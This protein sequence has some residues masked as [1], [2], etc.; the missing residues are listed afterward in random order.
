[1]LFTPKMYA[2]SA[3]LALCLVGCA[4]APA[5]PSVAVFPG[6]GKNFDDF[7][8]DDIVCRQFAQE[9]IGGVNATRDAN[10]NAVKNGVVGTM[11]GAVIGAAIGGRDGAA[12]GA[13]S[14][15]LVGSANGDASAQSSSHGM[16]RRYDI[17]YQQ[18]MYAKGNQ[19]PAIGQRRGTYRE[20]EPANFPPPN[21]PPPPP[22]AAP[23]R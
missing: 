7:R 16:Q 2:V 13:G 9:Q 3:T 8:T 1:M 21:T 14:G 15:L 11:V 12:V 10:D 20:A 5:G 17:A 22:N 18:C 23:P 19:V 4:T 6:T